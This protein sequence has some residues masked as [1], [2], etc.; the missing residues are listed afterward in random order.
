VE[1]VNAKN[2]VV[3]IPTNRVR[4]FTLLI[5]RTDYAGRYLNNFL[6]IYGLVMHIDT[7]RD[8]RL[9]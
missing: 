8:G 1:K 2:R 9:I 4:F 3:P 5:A 6:T 7:Y